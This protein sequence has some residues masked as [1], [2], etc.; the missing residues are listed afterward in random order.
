MADW[1]NGGIG[2][3]FGGGLYP[4]KQTVQVVVVSAHS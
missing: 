2:G 4:S 3:Q 1:V